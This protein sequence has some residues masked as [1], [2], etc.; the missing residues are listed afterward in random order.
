MAL[1]V[2]FGSATADAVSLHNLVLVLVFL[3]GQRC[4]KRPKALLFQIE[5]VWNLTKYTSV[6]DVRF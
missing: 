4:L 1:H 2:F 3:V 5:S 6:D